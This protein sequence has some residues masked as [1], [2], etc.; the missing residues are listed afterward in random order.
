MS[1]QVSDRESESENRSLRPLTHHCL[2]PFSTT[3]LTTIIEAALE[4]WLENESPY[5][6][7]RAAA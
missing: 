1:R 3:L 2:L 7:V 4:D 6:E 5:E